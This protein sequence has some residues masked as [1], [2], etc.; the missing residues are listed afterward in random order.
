MILFLNARA[1]KPKNRRFPLS[2]L[3]IAAMIE[4]R[5]EYSIVDGNFDPAPTKSLDQIM[6]RTPA[7][8]LAATVMPGPQMA[9]TIPVCRAFREKYP[10]VPIVWGGYFPSLY[11]D[12]TL[13]TAYVDYAV[14]GQGEDTFLEL[15]AALEGR[16]NLHE[17]RGLSFK[18]NGRIVHNPERPMR[19]PNDFPW[20]PYHR[21]DIERYILPT[22]LGSRTVVHHASIGCPFKCN[23]CGV[24][25]VHGS[26]QKMEAPERTAAILRSLQE[27]Y[28]IN[29]VQFYD[30]NFFLREDHAAELADRLTPLQLR[31]WSE[32]RVDTVLSYS[33]RTLQKLRDAGSAMIFFG[34]ESASDELLRQMQKQLKAEQTLELAARIRRFGIIPEFSFVVGNPG[35]PAD[36]VR[37]CIAFIRKIK[38]LNPDA[39]IILQHYIPTPQRE[40][41]YGGIDSIFQFPTTPEEWATERWL[42]FT[43]RTDPRLAW[44]PDPIKQR[45]DNFELVV[46]SRWPTVQDIR[47]P[48]WGRALL[49]TLSSWRY[50]FELYDHPVELEW[51]QK[52][53]NLRKPR[54]ESL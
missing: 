30:N 26:R 11:P 21:L 41:M 34:A 7:R 3:A 48:A 36:D 27:R 24:V 28:A 45:V 5:E 47:L 33:D 44:L 20:M 42:N 9:A 10:D 1:T 29:A 35:D 14:R 22:F 49:R 13:N 8:L 19:S 38:R 2:I 37:Q 46:N 25:P 51:C 17:I 4:G 15:L 6:Q 43:I 54:M 50:K 18:E 12:A 31:W 32:G 52:L 39:E 16:G 40:G 53:V 23:F